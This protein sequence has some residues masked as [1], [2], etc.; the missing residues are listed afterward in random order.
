[1]KK[2]SFAFETVRMVVLL[3]LVSLLAF[4]LITN[5]PIDPLNSYLGTTSTISDEARAEIA[6]NLGLDKPLPERFFDWVGGICNGDL[7]FSITY[8]KPVINVIGERFS[9]SIVLM[10][11][12]W[13][14][15]GI[16]GFFLGLACGRKADSAFDKIVKGFCLAMKSAPTFWVGMLLL[17]L[18]AVQLGWFPIGM[19]APIGKLESDVTIWDRIYHLILPVLT[20]T[21]TGMGEIV[22]Y[23][24]QRVIE[25]SGS[26][27]IL[28]A[29][30]RGE[31][32]RQITFRHIMRNVMLPFIT[33]QFASF[34]ELFGGMALAENVFAYPGI[35]SATTAA[36]LGGDVPLLLGI[37]LFSAIF[38]FAGNLMANILYKVLDPR[39]G[40]GRAE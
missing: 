15:S 17:A 2:R 16:V 25:V 18:F 37:A 39:I 31:N 23:T 1:M 34:S 32:E 14:L 38:V 8:K 35:G 33:L 29:K 36:A 4:V 30:A 24:R 21:I 27:F 5:S 13:A 9:Y 11:I 10:M 6:T 40:S 12:A 20:L 28:Y 22:L 19:A 3:I 26:N 7:G